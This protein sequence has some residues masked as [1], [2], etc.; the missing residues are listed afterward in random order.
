MHLPSFSALI[1][2]YPLNQSNDIL[3]SPPLPLSS[4]VP[5]EEVRKNGRNFH[6]N[7]FCPAAHDMFYLPKHI[8]RLSLSMGMKSKLEP[9]QY[10]PTYSH[11]LPNNSPV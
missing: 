11:H 5:Q 6:G 3:L 9:L 10:L 4:F 7:S 1:G 2:F 8:K